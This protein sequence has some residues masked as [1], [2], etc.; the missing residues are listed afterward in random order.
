MKLKPEDLTQQGYSLLD[1][2]DHSE[3]VPFVRMYIRK[4]TKFSVLYYFC[5]IASVA[6]IVFYF[7]KYNGSPG[8]SIG[9]GFSYM[10][11]GLAFTLLLIP[12]HEFIHALA[13][14][15]QGAKQ[16]SYDM[17][18]KKFYF[19]AMA[20]KFVANKREFQIVALAPFVI[21]SSSA[22]VG[23]F[24][25]APLWSFAMLG[26]LL[27]HTACC[28]GDFAMLSY[29]DFHNDISVVTYDDKEN[30]VSYFYAK[31]N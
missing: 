13:Y 4:R 25:A 3:L 6:L 26:I 7:I 22:I 31:Q 9:K 8:F 30:K 5:N 23:L 20:D 17:H 21:I 16:T 29:F 18:L 19:L 1:K 14:K 15:S 10:S 12:L 27:M 11:Y 2:L 24:F 28:S